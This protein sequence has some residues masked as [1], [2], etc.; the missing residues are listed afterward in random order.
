M[1]FTMTCVSSSDLVVAE[2]SQL[3]VVSSLLKWIQ[4]L[5]LANFAFAKLFSQ[6]VVHQLCSMERSMALRHEH[7][8]INLVR[9]V[10]ILVMS[11]HQQMA[12]DKA[13]FLD[14]NTLLHP[15][16]NFNLPLVSSLDMNKYEQVLSTI[17]QS[18]PTM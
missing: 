11:T 8:R 15:A 7:P 12:G 4:N 10:N 1:N 13:Y 5:L 16:T 6:E 18:L 9:I 14:V 2:L 17:R 3:W